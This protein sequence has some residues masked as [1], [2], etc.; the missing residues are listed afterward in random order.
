LFAITSRYQ[1]L[2]VA[3]IASA[4]GTQI[5]YVTRRFLPAVADLTVLAVHIV[6][7]ADRL[8]RIAAQHLGDPELFWRVVDANPVLHPAELTLTRG[9]TLFVALPTAQVGTPRA[10]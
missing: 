3:T 1:D 6:G 10:F 5:R 2:P 4:D 8:D 9:R 7:D